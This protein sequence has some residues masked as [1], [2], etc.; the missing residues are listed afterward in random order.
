MV[1][2]SSKSH[3]F[4]NIHQAFIDNKLKTKMNIIKTYRFHI[5][6]PSITFSDLSP[7]QTSNDVLSDTYD[8]K[9]SLSDTVDYK[10]L[11]IKQKGEAI[12]SHIILKKSL[13]HYCG[14][15]PPAIFLF[16]LGNIFHR[17]DIE[18][19]SIDRVLIREHFYW[20]I[21]QSMCSRGYS[22]TPF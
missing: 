13:W 17:Y 3:L 5:A 10:S 6:I 18:I 20:K 11:K 8:C 19:L 14:S 1:P 2:F 9:L 22:Q 4:K 16:K 21:M 15:Y 12:S 7:N